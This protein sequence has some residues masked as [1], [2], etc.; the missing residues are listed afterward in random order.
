MGIIILCI[1]LVRT[2]KLLPCMLHLHHNAMPDAISL[3]H[4][5]QALR[6]FHGQISFTSVIACLFHAYS[7]IRQIDMPFL[8]ERVEALF[9]S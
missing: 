9:D 8:S 4:L 3:M 5:A 6:T 1:L 7:H 2:P